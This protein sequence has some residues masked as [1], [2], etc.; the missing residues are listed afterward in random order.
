ML[1]RFGAEVTILERSAQ[2][3]SH[4]YE[5]EVGGAIGE[6]FE[7]E[8]IK[9][10]TSA[11]PRSVRHDANQAVVTF[12]VGDQPHQVR[13]EKLLVAAGRHPNSD[14]IAIEK[15]G[16]EVGNKGQVR[17]N[18]YLRTNVP[19][20]FAGGDVIGRGVGGQMAARTAASLFTMRLPMMS[21]A[22]SITASSRARSS[23]TRR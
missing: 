12:Q 18:E 4:G 15:A 16:V 9:V 14:R 1:H 3:L 20:I 21:R 10:I 19:N 7:K 8:G 11:I 23:P 6:V 22:A 13:A 17:V 5:P 2:L